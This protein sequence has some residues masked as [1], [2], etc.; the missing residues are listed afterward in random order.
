[1]TPEEKTFE[2]LHFSIRYPKAVMK[3]P[4]FVHNIVWRAH[5][6]EFKDFCIGLTEDWQR[7]EVVFDT[8]LADEYIDGLSFSIDEIDNQFGF[9]KVEIKQKDGLRR[10]AV[11]HTAYQRQ[12]PFVIYLEKFDCFRAWGYTESNAITQACAHEIRML[13]LN[14]RMYSGRFATWCHFRRVISCLDSFWD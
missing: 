7:T 4:Y 11:F 8:Q 3:Y 1:M 13:Q 14:E 6:K 12:F 5:D 10:D 9:G 2:I